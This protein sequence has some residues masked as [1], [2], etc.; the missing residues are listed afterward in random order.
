MS[1]S[2]IL[3]P[4]HEE[5]YELTL[6]RPQKANVLNGEMIQAFSQCLKQLVETKNVRVLIIRGAGEWFCAGADVKWILAS[7]KNTEAD[8]DSDA[9]QLANLLNQ[10]KK[11]PMYTIAR[12]SG[13]AMGGGIG[14][15]SCCDMV[16]AVEDAEFCFGEL[17][18]GLIPATIMPYIISAMGIRHTQR[19]VLS[20]EKFTSQTAKEAGLIH[21]IVKNSEMNTVVERYIRMGLST[22]P[23]AFLLCKS[24]LVKKNSLDKST[25]DETAKLLAECRRTDEAKEGIISFLEKRLASW[26][27]TFDITCKADLIDDKYKGKGKGKG[28]GW[29]KGNDQ[30]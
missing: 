30:R 11:M 9:L 16:I 29:E 26:V 18:L 13:G 24:I 10:L 1:D 2:I 15:L 8:N 12:V 27:T 4:L 23:G 22:A 21:V 19:Y 3:R 28:K 14:L 5:V 25:I 17:K 7:G 20:A 6:N